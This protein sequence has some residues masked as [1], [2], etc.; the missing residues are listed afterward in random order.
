MQ[1]STNKMTEEGK[2]L[3]EFNEK[4]TMDKV[5]KN[6]MEKAHSEPAPATLKMFETQGK[7][8]SDI[9]LILARQDEKHL[10]M[11]NVLQDIKSTGKEILEQA[12]KTN[13]RVTKLEDW[14]GTAQILIEATAK[15]GRDTTKDYT[16]NK[17]RMW[18]AVTILVASGG[19]II[20]LAVRDIDNKIERGIK[21]A[22]EDNVKTIQYEN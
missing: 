11:D 20:T 15:D 2:Q 14:S 12:K 6:A 9:K 17:T 8:I 21:Q 10:A 18:T 22:L 19:V 4:W 1:Y 3:K 16:I 7:E 5:V 13:G